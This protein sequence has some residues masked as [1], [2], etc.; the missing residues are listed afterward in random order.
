MQKVFSFA[1][2][3][4]AL[5]AQ[6]AFADKV[7]TSTTL[8]TSGNPE[9]VYTMSNGNGYHANRLTAPTQT[10][11][12]YGEFAFYAVSGKDNAYYIY[13]CKAAKWLSFN[14]SS[15][16]SNQTGFVTLSDTRNDQAYF[17]VN[18]F[19]DEKYEIQPYTTS[20]GVNKYLNWYCGIGT[21][22]PLD[23]SVS[24][25]LYEDSGSKDNGSSWT[26][27]E[28]VRHDYAYTITI[29]GGDHI[30]IGGTEYANGST[31]ATDH[32]LSK[33]DIVAPHVDGKF[34]VV[35][36]DDASETIKVSYAAIPAQPA[37]E[38]YTNAVL[39]PAQQENVGEAVASESDGAYT[40]SNKVLAASFVRVD[41]ALYFAGSQAMNL[42]P[43]TEPFTVAFG[44][45]V[46]VPASAMTLSSL[47]LEDL[48]GDANAVGGAEH[49]AGKALVAN[50]TYTNEGKT[51]TIVWKAVLRDGSHYLRTEMELTGTDD[52]NMYNVIPLI[53][54]VDTQA[55]GSTPKVVGN[56]RGAVLLSDKI[57]AGLEN[58]VGYNT[59]GDVASSEELW[60][61]ADAKTTNLT[62]DSWAQLAAT[63]VP[64]GVLEATGASN[65]QVNAY[66]Y[67]NLT[68]TKG[69]KVETT[70]E[71]TGGNHRLNFGGACLLDASGNDVAHDYHSGYSGSEH[72]NNTFTFIAPSNGTFSLRVFVETK[73]ETITATSKLTAN[74]YNAKE[75]ASIPN[76]VAIQGRWSRNTTL[77]AGETWKIS[78]VVGLV[79]QDGTQSDSNILKTQKR[80][81]FLAYSERERAVPWRANPAYISWYELN[82]DRNNAYDP[83][84]NMNANQVLDV[85]S[86]WKTN[87]YD[88]YGVAPNSFV[89]DDGWD[90]Y[91]TWTFHSGFPN[92]MRD[93]AAKAAEMGAGVGAWLGPVGGYGQSGDYRRNYWKNKG[94]MVLSN[95]DYYK[96]FLNAAENLTKNNGDFRFFKFDGISAQGTAIGPDPGDTGNENAEGI[97]RLER[98]VRENLKRD[99]FFNTTVGTWASPFWYHYTDATWRQDADYKEAGN[100]SIDRENWITYRDHMV[101]DIY[102][103]NS[104]ICPINTLMT[105]GFILSSHGQVSKNMDY[106]GCLREMRCAF[107][108][109]SGMVEL[110][111]DYALLNSINNG[112]LWGDLAECMAWQ[113]KNADVL[114]DAHWVGGNPW[115]GSKT[116]V[117]G[118]A[119]WNGTKS[120]LALRNGGNNASTY[121]FTLREALNIP[122]NVNGSVVLRKSFAVQDAL[123]GLTE[124]TAINID[125]SLSVTLP[126]SSVFCFDGIDAS[127]AE[128][129][130]TAIELSTENDSHEVEEGKTLVVTATVTPENATNT[131]LAW[132]SSN[133]EVATVANGLVKGVKAGTTTITATATDGSDVKATV[134]I[135]VVEAEAPVVEDYPVNFDKTA[136][137]SRS[138]RQ[139]S[140]I[141]LQ[142]EGKEKQTISTTP[143][144]LY[145]DLSAQNFTVDAGSE[146]TATFDFS[147]EWMHGYVYIDLNNDKQFS[148]NAEGTDQSGTELVAYS[149]YKDLNSKGESAASGNNNLNPPSFTAPTTP[150]TYR[151]RYKIDWDNVDPGGCVDAGNH[152]ST[153]G[154]G[155]WDATLV[156]ENPIVDGINAV[157][158][159]ATSVEYYDLDGRR[160]N[161]APQHGVFVVKQGNVTKKVVK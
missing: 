62:V 42:E 64:S 65:T 32:S 87:M 82:I 44:S 66:T 109:G 39:Y 8:P 101:Y 7:Q 1:I 17:K 47:A 102:V 142:Q 71:Y 98:Y 133:E 52:V 77:A 49:Y 130:V 155:I 81:S 128:V 86:Q 143:F 127:V 149:Y 50:Y 48:S 110:Y 145:E 61:L 34:A 147:G 85:L 26:F 75:G 97:I 15:T 2:A 11:E 115:D 40:L 121:T 150:G 79:V 154:G 23:G 35:S 57:F 55:A 161:M 104:P 103:T 45:G 43:G 93:I 28:V 139:N 4:A 70:V 117:Y 74:I 21:Q 3:L 112:K 6:Q 99:I 113:R 36:I 126:G 95:P 114:P 92:E 116:S 12:N 106:E 14:V 46:N 72:S 156:V 37:T 151:I 107:A 90:N 67:T 80:R 83:T 20:G 78:G 160:L 120:T 24:V 38:A 125:Q 94:G 152:I 111:T 144:K 157:N 122:A 153:N 91:G 33:S 73:T 138:D 60:T 54:N 63:E 53:Y 141:S 56:T 118:W 129:K 134:E 31:Y 124:G 123:N 18:N 13:S 51:L 68:L 30:S 119:S 100:N 135:T 19:S 108:C 131:T 29:T 58:P 159:D 5:T 76:V 69:Q 89:I 59:V 148:W 9:H 132:I 16:Y 10:S 146:L 105:H 25:G 88:R 84:K 140:S 41:N 22:N 158:A 137:H 136:T 27:D 96:T